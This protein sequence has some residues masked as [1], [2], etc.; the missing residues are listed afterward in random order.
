M[1]NVFAHGGLH[2]ENNIHRPTLCA[3]CA[4]QV[5]LVEYNQ[6]LRSVIMVTY[7]TYMYGEYHDVS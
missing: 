6:A 3:R 5:Q 1:R 7:V 2:M 4:L